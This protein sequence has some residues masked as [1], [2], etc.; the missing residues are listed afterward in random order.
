MVQPLQ[1][2]PTDPRLTPP[3][4]SSQSHLYLTIPP[5]SHTSQDT[6]AGTLTGYSSQDTPPSSQDTVAGYSSRI[7][8]KFDILRHPLHWHSGTG[9]LAAQY[10]S[11]SMSM[12]FGLYKK[13]PRGRV[14]AVRAQRGCNYSSHNGCTVTPRVTDNTGDTHLCIGAQTQ[15]SANK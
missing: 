10:Q 9:I 12:A 2:P 7:A 13:S 14:N 4:R 1:R 8:R 3:L 11:R 6:V 5:L 15:Y